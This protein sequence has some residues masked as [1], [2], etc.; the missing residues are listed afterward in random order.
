MGN[1]EKNLLRDE[2]LPEEYLAHRTYCIGPA[3]SNNQAPEAA[4]LGHPNR[5]LSRPLH[6]PW[7]QQV[8]RENG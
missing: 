2:F 8:M 3:N 7:L 6:K 1:T 4:H 5:Q